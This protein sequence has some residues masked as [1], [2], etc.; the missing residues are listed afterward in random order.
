MSLTD[1]EKIFIERMAPHFIA[2]KTIQQA[3]AAVI[4]DDERIWLASM[5]RSEMGEA[6]RAEI[7]AKVHAAA[8]KHP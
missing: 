1:A 5:E 8:R 4:E 7:C 3:A 6:I 2:G